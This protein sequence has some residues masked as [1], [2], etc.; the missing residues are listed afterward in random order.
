VVLAMAAVVT[1]NEST[2]EFASDSGQQN[3][4][5]LCFAKSPEAQVSVLGQRYKLHLPPLK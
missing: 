4:A 5:V 3:E 2:Q 1:W